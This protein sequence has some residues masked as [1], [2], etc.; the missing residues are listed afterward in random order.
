[1]IVGGIYKYNPTAAS[2]NLLELYYTAFDLTDLLPENREYVGYEGSL[3]TPPCYE[4]VRWHVMKHTMTVSQNQLDKF[5]M[6]TESS[7]TNDWMHP[8]WRELQGING[9]TIYECQADI[10][11]VGEE[12]ER[13]G[14]KR[15]R[16][17][18]CD[19]EYFV[20]FCLFPNRAQRER[21]RK[22]T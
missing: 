6:M 7:E 19:I 12:K 3:T 18:I 16:Y 11:A 21:E 8:N 2:A 14:K 9:R 22:S 15:L 1:M 17:F 4:T 13:E 5:R 10:D 20:P